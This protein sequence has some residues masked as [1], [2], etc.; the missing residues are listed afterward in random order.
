MIGKTI[1]ERYEVIDK[2]GGGGMSIVY[3]AEDT[4]LNRKVAI[5][6]ISIPPREKEETLKRFEREVHNSAQLSHD[7]I[8]SMIDVDEEDDCFYLVMEY[9]EG[10]TLAEYIENH[11][12]LSVETAIQFTERILSGI[13]HAHDMR[14]VHRDI[15]PQNILIVKNKTLK[16]FD[17][18]IAK[19]LSETSLTQTNHVLGTVQYLSPE[20]AKGEMTDES[21]DIYSIGI[22][23]YEMLVGEPPFNGET[24]VSIAIKHIQDSIPNITTEKR[25]EV[26]QSLSNV[27]LRATEKDKTHRYHTV[28]EMRDDLASALHENRVNEDKYELDKTKTVPLTREELNQTMHDHKGHSNFNK[29]MQIPIVNE[30]LQ[31]KKFQ[32]SE[33]RYYQNGSKK[34]S[35]MKVIILSIVFILLLIAL[36]SFVAMGL[37]RDKYEE[38]PDILGK[39]EKQAEQV[40]KSHHLKLGDISR[41][42]SDKYSENQVIKSDPESGE[43]VEQGDTVD[44]VISKGPKKV[45]M[46]NLVGMTKDE[47]FK[48]LKDLGFKDIDVEQAY[49]NSFEKGLISEQNVTA[50]SEVSLNDHHIKIYESL[51]IRQVYVSNYENK[52][53]ETAKKE[54]EAKGFKV[55]ATKENNDDVKKGNVITQSPKNKS[56][57]EGST[58]SLTV[59]KGKPGD[60]EDDKAVT[61]KTETVK[62]PYTGSKGKSQ[63]VEV[64]IRDEDNSGDSPAQ[65]YKIKMDK[66][67]S[68]PLK[69]AKGKS[70]GYTVRVDDKIVADKDVNYDD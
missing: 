50:N 5:K 10:P 26:P 41:S 70:A 3:L 8:V 38:I 67:I 52:S 17:F 55:Q 69:I 56:V 31:Q 34:P 12:P 35:K 43:R 22:V 60:S 61:T 32:S 11:G 7:N 33:S 37:F 66:T 30:P 64:F 65:T 1:N 9:V 20:Q 28:Q 19:A 45:K 48:K 4:I 47:A 51:G 49:S 2:L 59:S 58:I 27:V 62:V 39:S 13:K 15:K 24:A 14:I 44:I 21:T 18:G 6:A 23:L 46:P 68:I 53:Y 42:Y 36:I 63:T 16:I 54:L 40:L 57:D 25:E 29:T